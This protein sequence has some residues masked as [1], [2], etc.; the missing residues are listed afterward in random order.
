MR[1]G[2]NFRLFAGSIDWSRYRLT[3]LRVVAVS[4]TMLV[5]VVGVSVAQFSQAR[6][7]ILP[8]GATIGGD[9]VAFYAAAHALREGDA[10]AIYDLPAFEEKLHEHGPPKDRFGL[11]WQ[12]P[13]TYF[14]LVAPLA[15]LG[16]IPG[17]IAWTGGTA[18]AYFATMR[19]AGFRGL[20]LLVIL[21][22][23]STFHAAITGQ[24][25]FLTAA[26]I[27]IAAL[28]A[29]KRPVIAGLAAALL[30][31]KPQLGLLLP[32]AYLAGGCW[33]AFIVAALGAAGL[34]LTS[35]FV[36][37]TETWLAF[38]GA[39][40][41]VSDRLASGAMPLF[42]MTTPFAAARYAGLPVWAAMVFY[43]GFA[44]AAGGAVALVWRRLREAELRAAMLVAGVFLVAPY[45]FYYE[46]I[47]LALPIAI[48]AKR[49]LARGW[50]P[51]EQA[52]L[53]LAI[54]LPLFL[55]G[56][57]HRAGVSLGLPVI[58]LVAANVVRRVAHDYPDTFRFA[59][60]A[61]APVTPAA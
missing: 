20:F 54:A 26:L 19:A 21:A 57:A 10:A 13:P 16:F 4:A 33:R 30:T 14:F 1:A 42:K 15:F 28:Y 37:G 11:A 31:V 52:A 12:Y 22:A 5:L 2:M 39:V 56:D 3:R 48:L 59:G 60:A 47:V 24:N 43:A 25:G 35:A 8:G 38:L 7:N 46:M 51:F 61:P 55:P 6:D 49:G 45:G 44:V 41:A 17:Y 29:D 58:L 27:A 34:A 50:L 32:V 36:F 53:T 40:P 18:A 9:Y 23:P